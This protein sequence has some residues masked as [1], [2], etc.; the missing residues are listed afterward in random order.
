MKKQKSFVMYNDM[1]EEL[2]D[3]TMEQKGML[4][5]SIFKYQNNEEYE[6]EDKF[7]N[8]VLKI[9]IKTFQR[10]KEKWEVTREKRRNAGQQGGRP[11]KEITIEP[12]IEVVKETKPKKEKPVKHK[13]GEYNKVQ[14]TDNDYERLLVS[15]NNDQIALTEGIRI[16]D[17]WLE[18]TGNVRKNHYAV[19]NDWVKERVFKE[20]NTQTKQSLKDIP[21]EMTPEFMNDFYEVN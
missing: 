14:L 18:T 4:L 16:L 20:R 7:V 15:Y 19:M 6:T 2:E 21:I 13:Y 5:D 1:H 12:E 9:Y 11:K 8:F 3:L 10:D 17:T